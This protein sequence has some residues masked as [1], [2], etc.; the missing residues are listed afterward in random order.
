MRVE[1]EAVEQAGTDKNGEFA[2]LGVISPKKDRH[3]LLMPVQTAAH[4]IGMLCKAGLLA[5]QAR[6]GEESKV[7]TKDFPV[8]PDAVAAGIHPN[9]E[10]VDL[11]LRFGQI[12]MSVALGTS[13]AKSL[14]EALQQALTQGPATQQ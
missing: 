5:H 3:M 9:G 8:S 14:A 1:I 7:I 10:G 12:S 2:V 13:D 4:M 11:V 6:G